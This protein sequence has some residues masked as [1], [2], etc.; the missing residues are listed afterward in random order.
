MTELLMP[1]TVYFVIVGVFI[2]LDI[3][4]GVSQAIANHDL[5]SEKL[6]EGAW[7]KFAYVLIMALAFVIEQSMG[8]VD[9]GYS[10]PI[11]PVVSVYLVGTEIISIIENIVKLNPALDGSAIWKYFRSNEKLEDEV[12]HDE[13]VRELDDMPSDTITIE[14]VIPDQTPKADL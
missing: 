12:K 10:V 4:S 6:R 14:E 11:L 13:E 8:Y 5:S 1:P 7:H 2:I 3:I 9:I